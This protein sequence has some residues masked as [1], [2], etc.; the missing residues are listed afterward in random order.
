MKDLLISYETETGL[1][2]N[3]GFDAIMD[4]LDLI[5]SGKDDTLTLKC[6]NVYAQ[7]FENPLNYKRFDTIGD[8][9]LHCKLIV[10]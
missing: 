7:F 9:Y 10:S 5:E 8:L 6:K 3:Q 1:K 2:L 4:F